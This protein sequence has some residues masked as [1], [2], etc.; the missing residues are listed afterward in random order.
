MV[1]NPLRLLNKWKDTEAETRTGV[2]DQSFG[3]H[4]AELVRF[5]PKVISMAKRKADELEDFKSKHDEQ[6]LITKFSKEEVAAG[7]ALLKE[8]L[9]EWKNQVERT[10]GA[11]S[12]HMAR[13]MKDLVEGKW[14]ER[15]DSNAWVRQSVKTL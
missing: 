2:C 3:I 12:E 14:K 7:S 13:M 6:A 9:T 11:T 5:P 15:L 1:R 4:V 10:E 8:L